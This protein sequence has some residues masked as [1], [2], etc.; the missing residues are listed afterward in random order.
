[1]SSKA[2]I[3]YV[4]EHFDRSTR[5]AGWVM[6]MPQLTRYPSSGVPWDIGGRLVGAATPSAA[7]SCVALYLAEILYEFELEVARRERERGAAQ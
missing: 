1:M 2:A 6:P 3:E 5:D 4:K 7:S